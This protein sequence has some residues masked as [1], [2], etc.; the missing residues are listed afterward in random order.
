M[1]TEHTYEGIDSGMFADALDILGFDGAMTG[2]TPVSLGQRFHGRAVTVRMVRA[3][4]GTFSSDDIAL[5]RILEQAEAGDVIVIDVGGAPVT[6]W[7]ELTTI[8][9]QQKGV[10]GLVADGAIRDADIIREARFPVLTRHIVPTAGKT[11]LK[12]AS[13]NEEPVLCGGATVHPGDFIF[14]DDTGAVVCPQGM[15][16]SAIAEV[17]KIQKKETEFKKNLAKGLSYLEAAREL[18]LRQV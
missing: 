7:G 14:A 4:A 1:A 13:V 3:T 2:L 12:L 11:R 18:G 8:A 17:F 9:A 5:G 15:K 16:E 10:A 6:V